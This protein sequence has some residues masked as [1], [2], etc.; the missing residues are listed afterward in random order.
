MEPAVLSGDVS[1]QA[2]AVGLILE[3]K[4]YSSSTAND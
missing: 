4:K 1:R 3:L 2:L